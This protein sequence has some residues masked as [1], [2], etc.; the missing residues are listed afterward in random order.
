[1]V[2][3]H[4]GGSLMYYIFLFVGPFITVCVSQAVLGV[5]FDRCSYENG[6]QHYRVEGVHCK[7]N[8]F[9]RTETLVS[10]ASQISCILQDP[11]IHDLVSNGQLF[12][13]LLDY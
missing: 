2:Q 6:V 8:Q 10:T 5:H 13:I 3:L 7:T 12:I 9:D 11:K 1:M 4:R